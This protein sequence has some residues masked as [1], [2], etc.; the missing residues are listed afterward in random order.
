MKTKYILIF[1]FALLTGIVNAQSWSLNTTF[2]GVRPDKRF[3][4]VSASVG[5]NAYFGLGL[6]LTQP[7]IKFRW[8]LKIHFLK[9]DFKKS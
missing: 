2:P 6:S 3:S 1:Y 7:Y 9:I 5:I 8:V 4:G